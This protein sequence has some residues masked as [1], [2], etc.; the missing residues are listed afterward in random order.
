[1]KKL[2]TLLRQKRKEA[3]LTYRDLEAALD[4]PCSNLHKMELGTIINPRFDTVMKL[5]EFFNIDPWEIK[6]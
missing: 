6:R 4:I 3:G 5:C 2:K 1:M